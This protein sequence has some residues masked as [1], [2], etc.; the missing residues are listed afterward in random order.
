MKSRACSDAVLRRR[1]EDDLGLFARLELRQNG[2]KQAATSSC[3]HASD[4]VGRTMWPERPEIAEMAV[5]TTDQG[6]SAF[7]GNGRRHSRDGTAS[8]EQIN[9]SWHARSV[10][11]L[12]TIDR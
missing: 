11:A 10:L 6:Q 4:M 8:S 1:F 2:I 7:A 3:H 5:I 9:A 12:Q